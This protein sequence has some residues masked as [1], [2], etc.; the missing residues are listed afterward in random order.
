MVSDRKLPVYDGNGNIDYFLADVVSYS[1]YY[2]Y[3]VQMPG[4]SFQSDEYRYGFQGQE[5]D[6]EVKG[7]G[8]SINFKY[9]MHDPRIGR[10]FAV[11]PLASSY[12]HNSPY[13]FSENIVI[14]AI[15]LEGLEKIAL[16]GYTSQS[17]YNKGDSEAFERRANRLKNRGYKSKV[18]STGTD[19]LNALKQET[20]AAGQIER[21]AIFSHGWEQGVVLDWDQGLHTGSQKQLSKSRTIADL[22]KEIDAGN[23]SFTDDAI[24]YLMSCSCGK[25]EVNELSFA[26]QLTDQTGVTTVSSTGLVEPLYDGNGKNIGSKTTGIFLKIEKVTKYSLTVTIDG[27]QVTETFNSREAANFARNLA[28]YVQEAGGNI[29]NIEEIKET[30]HIQVTDLGNEIKTSEMK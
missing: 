19:I 23:I 30:E 10:F 27:K 4:R 18:V 29:S 1:D 2:P 16:S 3:G 13:A 12:P 7:E 15:E 22:S 28:T 14:N 11:D 6:D 5:K 26:F 9:R 20:S 24:I 25:S 17:H 8:N 21:V